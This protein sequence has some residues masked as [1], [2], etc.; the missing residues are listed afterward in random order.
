MRVDAL[1]VITRH[2]GHRFIADIAIN[3]HTALG[4]GVVLPGVEQQ[5]FD[6][7][8]GQALRVQAHRANGVVEAE[9]FARGGTACP[10][11]DRVALSVEDAE[12]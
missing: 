8:L 12:R 9:G 7:E 4:E 10:I 11:Q 5:A 2:Q 3:C 1:V 6:V